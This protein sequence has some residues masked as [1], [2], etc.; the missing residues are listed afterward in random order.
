[1]RD[2]RPFGLT[3]EEGIGLVVAIAAHAALI[4][5]LTLSPL[6]RHVQ[7]PPQ[8][9]TVTFAD[10]IAPTSTSPKPDAQPAPDLA[11]DLG[12]PAPADQPLPPAAPAPEPKPKPVARP[13]PRPVAKPTP[14]PEPK[15]VPKPIAKPEPAP[16][17]VPKPRPEPKP[18]PEPRHEDKPKDEVKDRHEPKAEA[19]P[20]AEAKEKHEARPAGGEPHARP[21][22]DKPVGGSRID[23]NFLKG[24]AGVT[25]PGTDKVSGAVKP[26]AVSSAALVSL[27]SRQIKPHWNAPHLGVDDDKL[28]TVLAWSLNPDG[29]L[30]GRPVVVS[31]SGITDVNRTQARIHA[32]AAIKAVELAAPFPLPA[33]AYAQWRR[34]VAFRFDHK[35][36]Q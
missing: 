10:T 36:S 34:V 12:E 2:S 24:I 33:Q 29:S 28:V 20:R 9:M 8:R 4:A 17:P 25:S 7:P 3:R 22:P 35:L 13:V 16:K 19:R 18:K 27:I 11:Q 14:K 26:A 1:M 5:A 23:Q 31:Q 15:P 21:H 30:A 6:G 32:E